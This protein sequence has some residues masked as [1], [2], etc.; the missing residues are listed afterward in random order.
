MKTKQWLLSNK[1][2]GKSYTPRKWSLCKV[3]VEM[4]KSLEPGERG[5]W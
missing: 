4:G 5:Q 3:E 2:L 1:G